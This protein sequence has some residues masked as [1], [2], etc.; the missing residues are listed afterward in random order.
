MMQASLLTHPPRPVLRLL[1]VLFALFGFLL[2]R[3]ILGP[4]RIKVLTS[5]LTKPQYGTLTL[6]GVTLSSIALVSS[7]GSLEFLLVKLPGRSRDYQ[8]RMFKTILLLFGGLALMIALLGVPALLLA[9]GHVGPLEAVDLLLCG[10]LLVL[11][12]HLNHRS[13]YLLGIMDYSRSRLTQL[14]FADLWFLPALFFIGRGGLNI[15]TVLWIWVGWHLFTMATTHRWVALGEVARAP[16]SRD[17]AREVLRF[18]WPLVPMILGDWLVRAQDRYVLLAFTDISVVASYALGVSIVLIGVQLGDAALDILMTEFFRVCNRIGSHAPAVLTAEAAVRFRFT[19]MVRYCLVIALGVALATLWLAEPIIRFMSSPEF[20][21]TALLLPWL[22]PY[23]ALYLLYIILSKVFIALN[24]SREMGWASF[25]NA[26]VNLAA[27]LLL[28]PL[29][30]G[31]GAA[32]AANLSMA[33]LA[34]YLGL[35]IRWWQWMDWPALRAPRLIALAACGAAVFALI[36][37][38]VSA[39]SFV[40]LLVAGAAYLGLVMLLG[41]FTRQDTALFAGQPGPVHRE[42]ATE[43]NRTTSP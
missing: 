40:K 3:F 28:V 5:L 13:F 33:A 12:V 29:C 4:I 31:R 35:R 36:A 6:I 14:M 41:L 32:V 7:L 8:H 30:Q 42:T 18:G 1:N 26:F 15:R 9:L 11:S 19:V 27:N 34:A 39:T 21:D 17:T 37:A 24:R 43:P 38:R 2:L 25:A 10:I 16:L 20:I 23:V 22:A